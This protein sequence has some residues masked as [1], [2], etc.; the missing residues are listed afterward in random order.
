MNNTF[1]TKSPF[2]YNQRRVIWAS[3]SLNVL[4]E[5]RRWRK[6]SVVV[7]RG[8]QRSSW[9]VCGAAAAAVGVFLEGA[10]GSGWAGRGQGRCRKEGR[11][12]YDLQ[13]PRWLALAVFYYTLLCYIHISA[14]LSVIPSAALILSTSITSYILSGHL[15]RSIL[16]LSALH[17]SLSI[18]WF[19]TCLFHFLLSLHSMSVCLPYLILGLFSVHPILLHLS[20]LFL[21]SLATLLVFLFHQILSYTHY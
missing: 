12:K 10:Y 18:S 17:N 2:K 4:V 5:R 21:S 16:P 11:G 20:L 7:R 19:S 3:C 14:C 15:Y 9:D 8:K 13:T 1:T 6:S